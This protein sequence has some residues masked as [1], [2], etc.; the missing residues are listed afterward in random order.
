MFKSIIAWWKS[1]FLA[2]GEGQIKY[3][4]YTSVTQNAPSVPNL[5]EDVLSM[6]TFRHMGIETFTIYDCNKNVY[7]EQLNA[8][9][10]TLLKVVKQAFDEN[11]MYFPVGDF[12][13]HIYPILAVKYKE[14]LLFNL[15]FDNV[16][17][18]LRFGD[19]LVYANCTIKFPENLNF[20]TQ[21]EHFW[22]HHYFHYRLKIMCEANQQK[23]RAAAELEFQEL[24]K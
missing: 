14:K 2:E 8:P 19:N 12:D 18:C 3:Q 21:N 6:N 23:R 7:P 4:E 13:S 10:I 17:Q 24:L 1:Q 9:V 16:V 20:L 15:V 11:T 22:I 5:T